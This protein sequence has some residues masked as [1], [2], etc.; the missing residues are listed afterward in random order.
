M[1]DLARP[2]VDVAP[3]L[4]EALGLA[5]HVMQ[6]RAAAALALGQDHVDAVAV[7]QRG[8]SPR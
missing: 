5:P 8:S 6:Q 3:R 7:E 2:D 4:G 1:L